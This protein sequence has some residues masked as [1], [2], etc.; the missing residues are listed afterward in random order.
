MTDNGRDRDLA[1]GDGTEVR[2]FLLGDGV[3]CAQA[4]QIVPNGYY[5]LDRMLPASLTTAREADRRA[6][7]RDDGAS[8]RLP[9][10]AAAAPR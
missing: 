8:G 7:R 5:D 9:E 2:T 6:D 3:S 10:H 4:G 1:T